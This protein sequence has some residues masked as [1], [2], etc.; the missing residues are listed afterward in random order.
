MEE[1]EITIVKGKRSTPFSRGILAQTL[2]QAG[3]K[4][5]LAHR[6][7]SE[8]RAE[9]LAEQ[10]YTVEEEEVLARVR[11]KL[12]KKDALVVERLDKWRILRESTEPIVVLIGGATGV[13]TSTLAAD[14]A[15]RLNIQ[16]VIGTDSIRE[17]LRHAI[18]PDLVPAL[19]KSSYA[20]KPEDIRIPVKEENTTLYGFRI[21][22]SQVAVG[23]E[24]I[25]DRGLKEGTNLVIEGVHLVPE[26]ILDRYRDHPNVCS[27]VVYLSDEAAHRSRFYIRALGT[28][29][30]RPAEEYIAHFG[31]IRQI[32]D[33][34]VESARRM[35]VHTVENFSIENSSDAAVEIVA[36]RVS[37]I[38]EK[39]ARRPSSL[40]L[41]A[42]AR[43]G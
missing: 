13:G 36:N 19:H 8:V 34:I 30:R 12:I 5:E 17:V 1:R 29:M 27:L 18:S 33:Y 42:S 21:Q 41:D 31:E 37:G 16:S 20:I 40:L 15:R 3:A 10:R 6:I 14:V 28:A 39:A 23:V 7:A 2:S 22:A 26:I 35:G 25:V 4:P 9:L 43:G 11:D 32:H 24:A 38:A